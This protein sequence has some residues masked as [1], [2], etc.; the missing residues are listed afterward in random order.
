[1]LWNYESISYTKQ[2]KYCQSD[3]KIHSF[4][5]DGVSISIGRIVHMSAI[6]K[7]IV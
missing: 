7:Y 5:A 6:I 2:M 4:N 3:V 1:M